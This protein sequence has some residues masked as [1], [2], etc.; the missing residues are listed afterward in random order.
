MEQ[1]GGLF[2]LLISV[3]LVIL[4]ILWILMP[5]LIMGTNHR[6]DRIINML[7]VPCFLHLMK[8]IACSQKLPRIQKSWPVKL[9]NHSIYNG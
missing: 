6:L 3:F 5:F 9:K 2:I 4:I 7:T 8:V 1:F